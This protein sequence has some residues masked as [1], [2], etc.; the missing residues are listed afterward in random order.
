MLTNEVQ[1][2]FIRNVQTSTV[3][4]LSLWS[5]LVVL[6]ILLFGGALGFALLTRRLR[7]LR[8]AMITFERSDLETVEESLIPVRR[9]ADELDEVQNVYISMVDRIREQVGAL[10]RA[11]DLRRE[12]VTNISH[13]LR[14]PLAALQGY[15]ETLQIKR[16][17]LTP[18][19]RQ[20]YLAAAR[21][22]G[23]RLD[24]L[25]A[26]LFETVHPRRRGATPDRG[27]STSGTRSRRDSGIPYRGRSQGRDPRGSRSDRSA[28]VAGDL[29]LIERALTNLLDNA[30]RH[31]PAGGMVTLSL[32]AADSDAVRVS[33]TDTGEGIGP[34]VL[35]RIIERF[36]QVPSGE[37]PQGGSG[38]GL[39]IVKRILELHG[40]SIP[41]RKPARSG[42]SL[43]VRSGAAE[44]TAP[45]ATGGSA[46]EFV[47]VVPEGD[48]SAVDQLDIHLGSEAPASHLEAEA[49]ESCHE[50]AIQRLR[51]LR[52]CGARETGA[53][54][55]TEVGVGV[56]WLTTS[57]AP[58]TAPASRFMRPLRSGKI[59]TLE[60]LVASRSASAGP[61]P[62]PT[63]RRINRPEAMR[64][65]TSAS[66]RTSARATR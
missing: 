54:A 56:N 4:R 48:R 29:G 50:Q 5:S 12:L 8:Q 63:P 38:L 46:L 19:E 60:I 65:T 13:D 9:P 27:V 23:D 14:T 24:K 35:P 15:L 30:V 59:R 40:S 6:T 26:Q 10:R 66:T 49:L 32:E 52:R 21:E 33:V 7:R 55:A 2:S 34:E 51:L 53:V 62:G 37:R 58:P 43:L 42:R 64:P 47:G 20:G 61:S 16:E 1:S 18:A 22:H 3:L 25:I 28:F 36:Y 41:G 44:L 11:D 57:M 39:A 45:L 17:S 31:T